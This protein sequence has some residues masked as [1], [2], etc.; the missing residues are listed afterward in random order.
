MNMIK[1]VSSK[2]A[3]AVPNGEVLEFNGEHLD[4]VWT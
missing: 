3:Y 1:K 4:T 2:L